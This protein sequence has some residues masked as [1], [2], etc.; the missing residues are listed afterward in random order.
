M[1]TI[2]DELTPRPGRERQRR[3]FLDHVQPRFR[4]A[5]LDRKP[6]DARVEIGRLAGEQLARAQHAEH[7]AVERHR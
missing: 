5:G 3:P 2:A 6:L 4:D 7:D 1:T